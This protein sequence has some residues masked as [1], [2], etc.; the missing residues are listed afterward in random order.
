MRIAD[1]QRIDRSAFDVVDLHSETGTDDWRDKTPGERLEA[2]E[3]LRQMWSNYDPTTA[4]LP[5]IYT[6]V[7]RARS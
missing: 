3:I 5:R 7:E 1:H 4:R 2:L 6:V